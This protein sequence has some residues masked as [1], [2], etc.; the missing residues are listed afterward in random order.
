MGQTQDMN[1]EM[2]KSDEMVRSWT[3]DAGSRESK[4]TAQWRL[5][6]QLLPYGE[7]EEFTFLDLGAG[8]GAA[9]RA[10]LDLY[11]ASNAIL[12]DFS[13]QMM[14]EGRRALDRFAGRFEYVEFD[15]TQGAWPEE[16]R[17]PLGA[18]ITSQCI[19]HVPDPRKEVLFTE[20]FERLAPGGWYLNFDPVTTEDPLVADAWRRANERQD[21]ES[22]RK[23]ANRTPQE[24]L[25]YENHIRHMAPLDRQLGYLRSAGFDAVD[26]Y[27]KHL[28]YVIYGGVRR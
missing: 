1:A 14:D 3:A 23:A 5:M 20:I 6:G 26:V 13:P 11:P 28:D 7:Q 2:W 24:Q 22:A 9:A 21:P 27:W 16:I 19:H 10:I 8:T 25:R 12:A 17:T 18:A 15:M 4:R